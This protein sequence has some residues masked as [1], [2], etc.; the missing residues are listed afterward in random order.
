MSDASGG[1]FCAG[2]EPIIVQVA[3]QTA[4]F[5]RLAAA[6]TLRPTPLLEL[7][8]MRNL[9]S[10]VLALCAG[11]TASFETPAQSSAP[12]AVQSSVQSSASAPIPTPAPCKQCATWNIPQAPFRLYGNAYYVGVHGLSSVLITS[13]RS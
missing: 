9:I 6:C 3:A 7:R 11:M 5:P 2:L 10:A 13:D 12:P 8:P 1:P 4:P